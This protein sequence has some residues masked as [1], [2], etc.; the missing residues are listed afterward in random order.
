MIDLTGTWVTSFASL[1]HDDPIDNA[2]PAAQLGG[3]TH[4]IDGPT[5]HFKQVAGYFPAAT[6]LCLRFNADKSLLGEVMINR[7]GTKK[8]QN[9]DP[10]EGIGPVG[11]TYTATWNDQLHIMEGTFSTI[12][13]VAGGVQLEYK[14]IARDENEL[15]WLWWNSTAH[16][17]PFRAS[18]ARGTLKR[19]LYTGP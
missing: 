2:D 13:P 17:A 15:E 12:Y 19:I 8:L 6:L 9:P 4:Q 16:G 14:Y 1:V 3:Y 5:H 11:G 18:V 10:A 7:G